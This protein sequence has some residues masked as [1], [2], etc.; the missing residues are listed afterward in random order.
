LD[1]TKC[2]LGEKVID[3]VKVGDKMNKENKGNICKSESI[4]L[5][6]KEIVKKNKRRD[7]CL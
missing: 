2:L 7:C 4:V 6:K 3:N 5:K 1:I